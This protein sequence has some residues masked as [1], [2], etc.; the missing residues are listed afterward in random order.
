LLVGHSW[1]KTGYTGSFGTIEDG[2]GNTY[3]FIEKED[4]SVTAFRTKTLHLTPMRMIR[5]STVHWIAQEVWVPLEDLQANNSFQ[6]QKE[7]EASAGLQKTKLTS[8]V[9]CQ[10]DRNRADRCKTHKALRSVG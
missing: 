8:L 9:I 5:L 1:F 3:E 4:F 2:N 7:L 10:D 6:I